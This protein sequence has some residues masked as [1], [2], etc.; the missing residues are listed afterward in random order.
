MYVYM[1]K[2]SNK[3][4]FSKENDHKIKGTVHQYQ[5]HAISLSEIITKINVE[6]MRFIMNYDGRQNNCL[7]LG[8]KMYKV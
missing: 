1:L 5:S 8:I 4:F 7:K 2:V 6:F 3:L